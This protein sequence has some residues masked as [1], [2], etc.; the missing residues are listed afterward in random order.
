MEKLE[1]RSSERGF[2][3]TQTLEGGVSPAAAGTLEES[4]E[5]GFGS[6]ERKWR[7]EPTAAAA[8]VLLAGKGETGTQS[9]LFSSC[10][11]L[12]LEF[13][14]L[15]EPN[16]KPAGPGVWEVE[17]VESWAQQQSRMWKGGFGLRDIR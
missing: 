17:Y 8:G 1:P 14:P 11:P 5:A 15:P 16:R 6:A 9:L 4:E 2:W 7:L 10:L 13:L 12:F 3:G